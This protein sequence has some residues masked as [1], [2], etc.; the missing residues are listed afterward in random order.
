MVLGRD[1]FALR[2]TRLFGPSR[3]CAEEHIHTT[4]LICCNGRLGLR[5]VAPEILRAIG[6][7]AVGQFRM[8]IML[9]SMMCWWI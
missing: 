9:L 6:N 5:L 1:A 4:G 3:D 2:G 7:D 8:G